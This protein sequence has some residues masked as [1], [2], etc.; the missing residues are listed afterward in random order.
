M[1]R[2]N[3]RPMM[4]S[5]VTFGL[6]AVGSTAAAENHHHNNGTDG[7]T[8]FVEGSGMMSS[9][10]GMG[11]MG[12]GHM[13]MMQSMMQ[14]H[15]SMMSQMASNGQINALFTD[16]A[17]D[18]ALSAFDGNG[19]GMM[20]IEEFA[21]WDRQALRDMMVDRFQKLDADG[22]GGVSLEEL[23]AASVYMSGMGPM[24]GMGG[25]MGNIDGTV[26][27]MDDMESDMDAMEGAESSD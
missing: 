6:L 24:N 10:T 14:M 7:E 8:P 21:A 22:S 27:N 5:I 18:A 19:D 17:P 4:L 3:L 15:M 1:Q 16:S 26:G 23:Q 9:M 2:E 20:D 12:G 11:E 25:F 13:A